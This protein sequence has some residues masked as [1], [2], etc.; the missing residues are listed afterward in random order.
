ME[1]E[2]LIKGKLYKVGYMPTKYLYKRTGIFREETKSSL[3]FDIPG[4]DDEFFSF[5]KKFLKSVELSVFT[6]VPASDLP[7][8]DDEVVSV[9]NMTS[10]KLNTIDT[11][12]NKNRGFKEDERERFRNY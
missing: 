1:K 12:Q 10:D 2:N 7:D 5:D 11:F 9:L 6:I 3:I 4:A 8:F